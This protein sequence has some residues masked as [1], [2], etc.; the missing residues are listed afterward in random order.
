MLDWSFLLQ[1]RYLVLD[2]NS[3]DRRA[4]PLIRESMAEHEEEATHVVEALSV[5]R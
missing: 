3:A 2:L 4:T 5:L 1:S